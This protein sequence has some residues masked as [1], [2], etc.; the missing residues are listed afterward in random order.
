MHGQENIK[1]FTQLVLNLRN[2]L[3]LIT[4]MPTISMCLIGWATVWVLTCT[5]EVTEEGHFTHYF[6]RSSSPLKWY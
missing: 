6:L 2:V 1:N 3:F 5:G 4:Q